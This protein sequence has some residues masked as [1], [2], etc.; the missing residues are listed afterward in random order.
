[1][2]KDRGVKDGK[3]S[4]GHCAL[5]ASPQFLV[6]VRAGRP[7]PFAYSETNELGK[8]LVGS[9]LNQVHLHRWL[10]SNNY[11][12]SCQTRMYI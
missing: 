9:Y 5:I 7:V 11:D 1:M 6:L 4:G 12:R 8:E 10:E 3:S 2:G